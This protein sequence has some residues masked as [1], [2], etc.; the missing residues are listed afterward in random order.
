MLSHETEEGCVAD[1]MM[2]TM[3]SAAV[4]L[5]R[6]LRV[7]VGIGTPWVDVEIGGTCRDGV[8]HARIDNGERTGRGF[9]IREARTNDQ[10]DKVAEVCMGDQW[11]GTG[12]E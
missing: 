4:R 5:T 6:R 8:V 11:I 2:E 3:N 9:V 7:S 1:R 10:V 12:G